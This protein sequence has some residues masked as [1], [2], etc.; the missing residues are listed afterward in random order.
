MGSVAHLP[1]PDAQHKTTRGK[2]RADS[3]I[4]DERV[5][6]NLVAA[7]VRKI[8]EQLDLDGVGVIT[9]CQRATGERVI[10]DGQHRVQ[11]LIDAGHG[12]RLVECHV[13]HHLS[14]SEE[15]AL[16]RVLNDTR[17]TTAYDD[18]TK[19]V[20]AGDEECVAINKIVEKLDLRVTD[21]TTA[22]GVRAVA[23]L[24][25][26]YRTKDGADTLEHAL[27]V[28][29]QAWGRNAD[30]LDGHVLGGIGTV[31]SRYGDELDLAV[32]ARKLA[33]RE[34]GPL[35]LL[36]DAKGLRRLRGGTLA[37]SVAVIVT[38]T[39]NR[40]RRSQLEAL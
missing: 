37:R 22:G 10:L 39:Y 36:G 13:H 24:R 1:A 31:V 30:A 23:T 29:T 20:T 27:S 33:K 4:R 21:Q 26:L 8:R 18:F 17:R 19:G 7:R 5:Q 14:I 38:D 2:Y 35:A 32:L 9:I 16:F 34:G 28:A 15:A 3:L 25:S 12:D 6:R 11:A 40:G